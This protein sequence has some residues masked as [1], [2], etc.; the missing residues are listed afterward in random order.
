[1]KNNKIQVI[2]FRVSEEKKQEILRIAY[3]NDLSVTDLMLKAYE[4][5]KKIIIE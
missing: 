1:M 4:F 2:N 5:Y 3:E